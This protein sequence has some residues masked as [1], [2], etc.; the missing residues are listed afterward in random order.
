M[1]TEK[2][3]KNQAKNSLK[4]NWVTVI[5]AI[6]FL[7]VMVI[8]AETISSVVGFATGAINSEGSIENNLVYSIITASC[9]VALFLVSPVANGIIKLVYNIGN[10]NKVEFGDIFFY[11]SGFGSYLKTL[12]FNITISAV[13]LILSYGF[14]FYFFMS[15]IIGKDLQN[16]EEFDILTVALIVALLFSIITKLLVYMLFVHYQLIAFAAFDYISATKAIFGIYGFAFRN[17]GALFKLLFSFIG[18][19]ALCFFVVPAFYVLPYIMTS[20]SVS[21]KWLFSLERDR[22]FLC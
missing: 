5:A 12:I 22:G 20:M 10:G 9:I 19:I 18:W 15:H 3:I 1:S 2:I 14:D 13:Y 21:A 16:I 8:A 4:D 11:F 6:I 17:F 7:C